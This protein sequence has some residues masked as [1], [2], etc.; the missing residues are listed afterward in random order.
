MRAQK[1]QVI[2]YYSH[3]TNCVIATVVSINALSTLTIRIIGIFCDVQ[4]F[5]YC[6]RL[7]ELSYVVID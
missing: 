6:F 4:T 5:C 7:D 2:N 3:K 1:C